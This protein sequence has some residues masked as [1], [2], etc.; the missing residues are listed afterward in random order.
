MIELLICCKIGLSDVT[1]LSESVLKVRYMV[2][3]HYHEKFE[4][5]F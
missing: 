2:F 5:P 3:V 1:N 4:T